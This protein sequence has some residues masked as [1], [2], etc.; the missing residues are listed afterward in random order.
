MSNYIFEADYDY[1][2][3]KIIKLNSFF[4]QSTKP[5]WCHCNVRNTN[6]FIIHD[7]LPSIILSTNQLSLYDKVK[8]QYVI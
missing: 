4:S 7:Q 3:C 2:Y 6:D 5:L 8:S 1:Q